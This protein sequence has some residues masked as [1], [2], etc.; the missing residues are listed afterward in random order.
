MTLLRGVACALAKLN[1]SSPS[2]LSSLSRYSTCSS[3]PLLLPLL[4][5]L[6][7][8]SLLLLPPSLLLLLKSSVSTAWPLPSVALYRGT[9]PGPLAAA[10]AA[11]AE[12]AAAGTL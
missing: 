3:E 6:P 4:L 10:A 9:R 1:S 8:L 12:A 5:L 7:A 2:A 11:I